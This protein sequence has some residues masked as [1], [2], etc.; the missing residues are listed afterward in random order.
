MKILKLFKNILPYSRQYCTAWPGACRVEIQPSGGQ[1][2]AESEFDQC[3]DT[4]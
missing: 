4:I 3:V 1:T 2:G